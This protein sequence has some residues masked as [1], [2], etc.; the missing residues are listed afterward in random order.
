MTSVRFELRSA[1][2]LESR[3]NSRDESFFFWFLRIRNMWIL[4]VVALGLVGTRSCRRML[5]STWPPDNE[6]LSLW[7]TVP[8]T[9]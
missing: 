1:F 2:R 9:D 7:D 8:H 4:Y 5:I 6:K 3:V